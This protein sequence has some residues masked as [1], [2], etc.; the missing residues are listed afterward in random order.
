MRE[1]AKCSEHEWSPR[2]LRL[3]C[4]WTKS[5]CAISLD[6]SLQ[7]KQIR[8]KLL[9]PENLEENAVQAAA[10]ILFCLLA[11]AESHGIGAAINTDFDLVTTGNF[12]YGSR[13]AFWFLSES[14][15]QD[16]F[17]GNNAMKIMPSVHVVPLWI[18]APLAILL[19]PPA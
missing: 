17:Y 16:V 2:L 3:Y 4:A 6:S 7:C 11:P 10:L 18:L 5:N 8:E 19:L 9:F 1:D 14:E 15:Y 13:S 12:T